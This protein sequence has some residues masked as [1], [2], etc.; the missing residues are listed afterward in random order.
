MGTSLTG[1]TGN[2]TYDSILKITDN[3][4]VGVT[5]KV[6]TDGLG[7]D[8]ALKVG[9]AGIESTGTLVVAGAS[10]LAAVSATTGSFTGA[11]TP[12][13]TVGIAGTT[14]NDSAGSGNW[15]EYG[16]SV[17][18]VASEVSLTTTTATNITS[19]SLTAGDYE[20]W[21][22]VIF[23]QA[24]TTTSLLYVAWVSSTSATLPSLDSSTR[25]QI[26]GTGSTVSFSPMVQTVRLRFS[27][28]GAST[29]Y[30]STYVNFSVSTMAAYG[31]LRWRRIR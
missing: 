10:T 13:S 11:I 28:S 15:G 20:A 26:L 4:P 14:T 9:T 27:L 19:V 29:I 1:Q 31:A 30:L 3:G 25:N 5:A 12:T 16:E 7:N 8:S 6:V 21:G 22:I 17:I 2:S 23:D 24:A 18:P